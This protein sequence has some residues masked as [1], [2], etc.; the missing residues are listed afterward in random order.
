MKGP[1][2]EY[3]SRLR[4]RVA[5]A[6]YHLNSRKNTQHIGSEGTYGEAKQRFNA[7][8]NDDRPYMAQ[9]VKLLRGS[10]AGGEARR[11]SKATGKRLKALQAQGTGMLSYLLLEVVIF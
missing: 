1:Q 11:Q 6:V 7:E 8:W 5:Y 4:N 10:R 3:R 2:R 9:R